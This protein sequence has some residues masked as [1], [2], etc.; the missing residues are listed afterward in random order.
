VRGGSNVRDRVALGLRSAWLRQAGWTGLGAVARFDGILVTL[1]GL[2][3]PTLNVGFVEW[4]PADPGAAL[5]AAQAWFEA[6]GQRIGLDVERGR[7]PQVESAAARLGLS[8]V[9]SRPGMARAVPRPAGGPWPPGVSIRAVRDG[10][11]L[12]AV[13]ALQRE[14]FGLPTRVATGFLPPIVLR[15]PGFRL[16]LATLDGEPAGSAGV[17]LDHGA[18]GIMGVATL[19]AARRRGIGTALTVG[20]LAHAAEE[21]CDLAWLQSEPA[22]RTIYD[23][24]GFEVVSEWVVWTR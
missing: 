20:C 2:L 5:L 19:P 24:L 15:T 18:A 14:V 1:T 17:H 22:A 13:R 23:R 16:L 11:D 8:P 12:D 4:P 6:N 7:H 3:E 21:G 9:V 10:T